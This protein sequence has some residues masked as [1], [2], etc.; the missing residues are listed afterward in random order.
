MNFIFTVNCASFFYQWR[1]KLQNQHKLTVFSHWGQKIFNVTVI[2]YRNFSAYVQRMIDCILQPH[3]DFFR[4]YI[5]NIVIYTKLCTLQDHLKHLNK[6]F[7]LLTE[8]DI[9][10]FSKKSFLD[11]LTVQ[12]LDQ[13]VDALKLTITEDKLA[14]IINIE[15]FCTLFTLKKYLKMTDYL[16]Q[17]ILYY[18]VII[19]PLQKKKIRLNYNLQKL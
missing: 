15:F 7:K 18:T 12:L 14:V 11:Y 19:R 1:V 6:V 8:K 5:D 3:W 16:H 2:S 13:C 9:C 4:V 17:Y 10:L